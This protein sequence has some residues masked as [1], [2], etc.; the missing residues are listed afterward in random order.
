MRRNVKLVA[1]VALAAA[2]GCS[3]LLAGAADAVGAITGTANAANGASRVTSGGQWRGLTPTTCVAVGDTGDHGFIALEKSGAWGK[4]RP[5]PDLTDY[6]TWLRSAGNCLVTGS[7]PLGP[8]GDCPVGGNL[9]YG[10]S[11]QT[12]PAP[13]SAYVAGYSPAGG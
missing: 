2:T 10:T 8:G 4:I 3:L 9:K 6:G 12:A 11:Y 13:F 7:A 5:V 1:A